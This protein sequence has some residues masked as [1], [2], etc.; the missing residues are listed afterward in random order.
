MHGNGN[1]N[2]GIKV[3]IYQK[4]AQP[5]DPLSSLIGGL[6]IIH[7]FGWGHGTGDCCAQHSRG[8][9]CG[10]TGVCSDRQQVESLWPCSGLGML[11]SCCVG[12]IGVDEACMYTGLSEGKLPAFLYCTI[13]T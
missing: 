8:C 5:P 1:F 7:K 9:D 3:E 10:S 2:P 13:C 6:R 12:W 4:V 11:P